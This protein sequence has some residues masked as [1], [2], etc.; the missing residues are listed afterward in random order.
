MHIIKIFILFFLFFSCNEKIIEKTVYINKTQKVKVKTDWESEHKI[1]Y[2]WSKPNGPENHQS[3][4][5]VNDNIMLFT[6]YETGNYLIE[7]SI[8]NSM[9]KILGKEKFYYNVINE[10]NRNGHSEISTS[11]NISKNNTKE[12]REQNH[13][14]TIQISSWNDI[15]DAENNIR[16][17][18]DL[19][20]NGYVDKEIVN[21][22]IWYRVRI[23]KKLSY[24]ESQK[25]KNQ[26]KKQG[27][28][29]IWI[30]KK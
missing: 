4:W 21:Q 5:I 2:L 23:G 30:D 13:N 9:G 15:K 25:I 22:K 10:K 29:N 8:E 1:S 20:F 17:L 26:L 24:E 19:G 18:S 7:V 16:K 3:K 14:Y 11:K 27:I 6:P 12:K 28:Q